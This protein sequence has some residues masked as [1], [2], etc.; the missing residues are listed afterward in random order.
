[1][2]TITQVVLSPDEFFA[3]VRR[4][5]A[6]GIREGSRKDT[7][8][9]EWLT[10]KNT[11]KMLNISVTTLDKLVSKKK[12][13]SSTVGRQRRFRIREVQQYLESSHR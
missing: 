5:V 7:L 13:K 8:E 12:I 2:Q 6:E 1:M 10:R 9:N 3:G 4:A 11:A